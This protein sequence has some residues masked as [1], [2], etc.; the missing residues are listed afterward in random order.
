[1]DNHSPQKLNRANPGDRVDW[2]PELLDY[3]IQKANFQQKSYKI[4]NETGNWPI[5]RKK[6]L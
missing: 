1:M 6:D 4:F 3:N 5:Y 2:F